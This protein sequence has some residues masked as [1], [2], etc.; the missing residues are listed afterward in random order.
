MFKFYRVSQTPSKTQNS[1]LV[2]NSPSR[3]ISLIL[4]MTHK[5]TYKEDFKKSIEAALIRTAP[6]LKTGPVTPSSLKHHKTTLT[7]FMEKPTDPWRVPLVISLTSA[8]S[9]SQPSL[10]NTLTN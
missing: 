5:Q 10:S 9:Q 1:R 4:I 3:F 8:L 2:Y 6:R 7:S